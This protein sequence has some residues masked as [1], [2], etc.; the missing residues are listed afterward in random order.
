MKEVNNMKDKVFI[1]RF[2]VDGIFI[3]RM[4]FLDKE[5]A[6]KATEHII[7]TFSSSKDHFVEIDTP[8]REL[9]LYDE[10]IIANDFIE[11]QYSDI[12]KTKSCDKEI[13][14]LWKTQMLPGTLHN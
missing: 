3:Y 5:K 14:E 8:I 4:A 10:D 9:A 6:E 12:L 7:K 11:K 13:I 2:E 1:V